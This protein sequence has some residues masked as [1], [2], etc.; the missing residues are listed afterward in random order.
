M[1]SNVRVLIIDDEPEILDLF[2]IFLYGEFAVLT[3]S[4]GFEALSLLEKEEVDCILVDIMMPV[5]DGIKFLSRFQ[6]MAAHRNVPVI[7]VTAFSATLQEKSLRTIGFVDVIAKP[8]S[9]RVLIS[10]V[11]EVLHDER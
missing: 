2:E 4:N 9:R 3:A 6:K 1:S 5:M 8:V 10:A 7:A 11:R